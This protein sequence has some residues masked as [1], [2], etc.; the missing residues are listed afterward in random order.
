MEA[1][2]AYNNEAGSSE[3]GRVYVARTIYITEADRD[4]L[5]KIIATAQEFGGGDKN[6]LDK[7]VLELQRAEVVSADTIPADVITMNSK[8]VLEDLDNGDEM[9]YTLVYPQDAALSQGKISVLAP[10][11]TAILGYRS[12]DV[13]DWEVPGG[14][15]RLQVKTILYQPEAAGDYQ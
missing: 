5:Q 2:D 7:L 10:I 15:A 6:Y 14:I 4:K 13:I 11:G 9:H 8:V 3:K 12:G 1:G